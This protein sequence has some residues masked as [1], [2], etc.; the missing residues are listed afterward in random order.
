MKHTTWLSR[1]LFF[2]ATFGCLM[3]LAAKAQV[4]ADGT[5]STIVNQA[6]NDFT[7]EQGDRIDGEDSQG[8]PSGT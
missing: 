3:P 8:S 6:G 4:T 2:L 1:S 5:T 7:I